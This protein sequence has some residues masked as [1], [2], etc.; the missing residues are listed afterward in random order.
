MRR[1]ALSISL[2]TLIAVFVIGAQTCSTSGPAARP[3]AAGSLVIPMD[4]C[5]QKR[6]GTSAPGGQTAACNSA[7]D[8]GVFRA[9]GLVYFLLKHNVT[10][11]WA[12]DGATPK[13]AVTGLDVTVP[14]GPNPLVKKLDWSS[15]AFNTFGFPTSGQAIS[16]IGGPYIIDAA[17]AATAK[18][19]LQNHADFLRFRTE[20]YVDI[21]EV[22][23]GF[24]ATQVR[25]LTGPPPRIAILAVDPKPY[26]KTSLDVMYRYAV[27]AGLDD[28]SC[29][30]AAGT[31]AGGLGA[32]CDPTF[33]QKYLAN[34]I[35]AKSNYGG[36]CPATSDCSACDPGWVGPAITTA[37]FNLPGT[38]GKIFDIL[39]DGDFIPPAGK[40]YTDT[41][42]SKGGY[43][44]L[45]I[46]HWDTGG[47][48]P[49]ASSTLNSQLESISSYVNAGNN[50]FAEC[51][52][53]GALEGGGGMKG[54]SA[55]RFQT[56]AGMTDT[57]SSVNGALTL[58]PIA[59]PAEPNM[60]IGD[61]AFPG[62]AV[63][64]AITT[65][66]PDNA[67]SNPQSIY[68]DSVERL[69]F[70]TAG[71][72]PGNITCKKNGTTI[73]CQPGN[74]CSTAGSGPQCIQCG[75]G[76]VSWNNRCVQPAPWDVATTSV[77]KAPDGVDRGHVA[78]LGGHDYS[79]PVTGSGGQT[80]G[81]RIVLNTL[82]NLG[83]A[84]ADPLDGSGQPVTCN[85]GGLGT[86]ALGVL[87]CA[88]GGGMQCVPLQ[89]SSEEVC[90]GV[91][92]DC[93]GLIDDGPEGSVCNP[94]ACD[95]GTTKTC[96]S[97]TGT[98]G[99]GECREG[100]KTC[101]GGF[102]GACVGQVL[103]TPEVCNYKDDDCDGNVDSEGLPE[104][105]LCGDGATCTGGVCLPTTCN[106]ENSRCPNGFTCNSAGTCDPIPCPGA[107]NAACP[108]GQVCQSDGQCKDPCEGVSCG[109]GSAC[110]GGVCLG[111]GC[112]LS[113]CAG[114]LVC[115]DGS[116]V[117]D[118]CASTT[119]P[120]GTFCRLGDCVRSCSYVECAPDHECSADGFCEP[121][122]TPACGA[123]QV[124][125]HGACGADPCAGVVCGAGQIC[126]GGSCFDTPCTHVTCE[127][128][129][130]TAGQCLGGDVKISETKAV[131]ATK[132]G[133]GCG[134]AGGGGL[135]SVVALLAVVAWRRCYVLR[136]ELQLA[137]TRRGTSPRPTPARMSPRPA[138][139]G[140]T[141]LRP[142]G[143]RVTVAMMVAA[144]LAGATAT[145]CSKSSSSAPSC[146][147]GQTACGSACVDLAQAGDNCGVCG[148]ACLTG[149]ACVAGGC[150]I[151]TP[152]P[153]L[154]S[155][156]PGV[157]GVGSEVTLHLTVDGLQDG[158]KVRVI[159]SGMNQE[160]DLVSPTSDPNVVVDFSGVSTGT[161]ELQVLNVVAPNR[162]V[163]NTIPLSI[164][165]SLVLRGASPAGVRQDQGPV[166]LTLSGAGFAQGIA[167]NLKAP[168]GTTRALETALVDSATLTVTGVAPGELAIGAYDLTVLNPGGVA[169]NALKFTVTE[170]APTLA[171]VTPTCI[172]VNVTLDG[173]ATGSY[174]YPSSVVRV[175]GGSIVDSP[176]HTEC[177][178]GTDSLGRCANGQL[179]VTGDLAGV[180]ANT[181]VVVVVNPGSPSALRSDG[182]LP[183][184]ITFTI[185]CPP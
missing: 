67:P 56:S 165:D 74:Y 48:D 180:P 172:G 139:A 16:Y 143:G 55:T 43:K 76:L 39:C 98:A 176:L 31:C 82:F 126:Q 35:C 157:V 86:C 84:C 29:D 80:A 171:S 159:G 70:G 156:S 28:P 178:L 47:V 26:H 23:N 135:V 118:P 92:N 113:G 66:H 33:I 7:A 146:Q 8:D 58:D 6:D 41:N 107:S 128:G 121:T 112:A 179:R 44:M 37:K 15:F 96:Y 117:E 63:D 174:F 153:Y 18:D 134:S 104:L 54:I 140:R 25:P 119:C 110:S 183:S 20:K 52:G 27:A 163:S 127:T 1:T 89:A 167:A 109:P 148:R 65:F 17:D 88:S 137:V 30:P 71:N 149:F 19:L 152:N 53:I 142:S 75:S 91:D 45:W 99:T 72:K 78:Y 182:G 162:F 50:L 77:V 38:P 103:P 13:S 79:P 11:Y 150:S 85:T 49:A 181:Y 21:H 184:S 105:K 111:G 12:I 62:S 94:S 2:L 42:L 90:D 177:L 57:T 10:V 145:G 102:W 106:S 93:N 147:S 22:E 170:G 138:T 5:Y 155:V 116:C 97:G 166:S 164:T 14:A 64:G 124:C 151:T 73:Y 34:T 87:K 83:F 46:P 175:S 40:T 4:N 115:V 122:C 144:L 131:A 51:L 158:A 24:T 100:T 168:D 61:F 136:P 108:T 60:Q 120:Q 173:S 123:G 125:L 129:T 81:T 95:S 185:P 32:S 130:C 133:G 3:F 68:Q 9:Y 154:R 160:L 36:S 141:S 101:T 114:G 69:I 161:V 169:S 59:K 132:S